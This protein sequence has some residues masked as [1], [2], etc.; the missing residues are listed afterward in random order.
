MVV[1]PS[2]SSLNSHLPSCTGK[3]T[4]RQEHSAYMN[5]SS[6][7]VAYNVYK[8][9]Y[10]FAHSLHNLIHCK[11]GNGPFENFSCANLNNVFPWQV[12]LFYGLLETA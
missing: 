5:T 10:A 7:R 9:V 8:A 4:L 3:E 2:I 6:P 12:K 1:P 11:P